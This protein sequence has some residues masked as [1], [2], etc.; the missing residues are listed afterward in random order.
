MVADSK[1]LFEVDRLVHDRLGLVVHSGDLTRRPRLQCP[2][3]LAYSCFFSIERIDIVA[4]SPQVVR[5]EFARGARH[6]VQPVGH[7]VRVSSGSPIAAAA[8]SN[9]SRRALR[10]RSG[11]RS[12]RAPCAP[13]AERLINGIDRRTASHRLWG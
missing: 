5:K 9:Q 3:L 7:D 1:L 2:D 11:A 4:V 8:L 6:D 10:L 12:S 13:V